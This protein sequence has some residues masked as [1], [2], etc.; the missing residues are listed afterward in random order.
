METKKILILLFYYNRPDIVKNALH[1]IAQS[2]YS[3]FEIAFINDSENKSNDH[4]LA[5]LEDTD[6][7][8]KIKEYSIGQSESDKVLQGG[9]IF[10]KYANIAIQESDADIVIMLC[11]DDAVTEDYFKNLSEYYT[12]NPDVIWAYSKVKYYNPLIETYLQASDDFNRVRGFHG[13]VVNLNVH[14]TPINPDCACDASQVSFR[15]SCFVQGNVWFPY[16]QT[17]NLDSTIYGKMYQVWGVCHPTNFYGQCKGVFS[18]Q[19]GC[20]DLGRDFTVSNQ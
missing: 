11:D 5:Y 15:R 4:I 9:S 6:C 2:S 17:R 8:S 3:N 12:N 19:L 13:S 18:D 16:P 14:T 1:S 20:R 10:G 7:F